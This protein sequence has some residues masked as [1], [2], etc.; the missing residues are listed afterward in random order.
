MVTQMTF[1]QIPQSTYPTVD[2]LP[3]KEQPARRIAESAN[4]CSSLELLA[5]L[6]GGQRQM[7]AAAGLLARYPSLI[8]MATASVDDLRTLPGMDVARAARLKA[9]LEIGRRWMDEA[10][11]LPK[12]DAIYSPRDAYEMFAPHLTGLDHEEFWVM[13]LDRRNHVLSLEKLYQGTVGESSFRVAEVFRTAVR[14]TASKITV[15]H[16]HPSGDAAPSAPDISATRDMVSAGQLLDIDLVDHLIIGHGAY[17]SMR[18]RGVI[19]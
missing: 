8:E 13:C 6:V 9:G 14:R 7:E 1:L 3:L 19:K 10:K 4:Y 15:A 17:T 12:R 16:S 11:E 18:E 5:G 2:E